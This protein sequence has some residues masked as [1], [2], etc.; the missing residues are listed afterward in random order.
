MAES[1]LDQ[2]I[3]DRFIATPQG[4]N[5]EQNALNLGFTK[6]IE[7]PQQNIVKYFKIINDT[8]KQD[9]WYFSR[10]CAK[11]NGVLYMPEDPSMAQVCTLQFNFSSHVYTG[12]VL[13]FKCD[14][15]IVF[16]KFKFLNLCLLFDY[17]FL[18]SS[19]QKCDKLYT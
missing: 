4:I 14:L 6:R 3:T 8:E 16:F 19:T 10:K 2:I 13:V 17:I 12:K 15:T 11:E 1:G 5:V 7:F 9:F 18:L